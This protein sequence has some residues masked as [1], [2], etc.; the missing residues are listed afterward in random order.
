MWNPFQLE[1][2]S[3]QSQ[4][5]ET[6]LSV[7]CFFPS[8]LHSVEGTV[9][10]F[11]SPHDCSRTYRRSNKG[12][13]ALDSRRLSSFWLPDARQEAMRV[14]RKTFARPIIF[15]GRFCLMCWSTGSSRSHR[16][17]FVWR[18]QK[19]R[20]VSLPLFS[21]KNLREISMNCRGSRRLS[22]CFLNGLPSSPKPQYVDERRLFLEWHNVW[23]P[24]LQW[25]EGHAVDYL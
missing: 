7:L 15:Q 24:C 4:S 13:R 14:Q 22:L 8:G 10:H 5:L 18:I 20:N 1:G 16:G 25:L 19:H 21:Q 3:A 9:L 2:T 17:M 12:H 6:Q 23:S 11:N